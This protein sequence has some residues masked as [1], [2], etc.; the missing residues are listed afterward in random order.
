MDKVRFDQIE[1]ERIH[2][3]EKFKLHA[4]EYWVEALDSIH[5]EEVVEPVV[6]PK[7]PVKKPVFGKKSSKRK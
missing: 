1:Y 5:V 7:K 4:A 6:A 3:Y 2:H